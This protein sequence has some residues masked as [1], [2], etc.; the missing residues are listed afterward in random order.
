[1]K[2][3]TM[4]GLRFVSALVALTVLGLG[5]GGVARASM[6]KVSYA[7]TGGGG[8]HFSF[9]QPSNPTPIAYSARFWDHYTRVAITNWSGNISPVSSI[10][11]FAQSSGAAFSLPGEDA[12]ANFALWGTNGQALFSGSV[13]HPAFQTGTFTGASD[14][15]FWWDP[16]NGHAT[17]TVTELAGTVPEPGSLG[18]IASALALLGLAFW[19]R[20]RVWV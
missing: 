11:W 15:R 1:M 4:T 12:L 17:L 18:L 7:Q 3:M 16:R 2:T 5:L 9:E 13:A 8:I 6:L 19:A 14:D 10:L 20:R